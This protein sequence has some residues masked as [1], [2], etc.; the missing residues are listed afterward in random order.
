MLRR[1]EDHRPASSQRTRMTYVLTRP[2]T[3]EAV[4]QAPPASFQPPGAGTQDVSGRGT[5]DSRFKTPETAIAMSA[6]ADGLK[7]TE[8]CST[9]GTEAK[10]KENRSNEPDKSIRII[11][12]TL[13]TNLERT[14]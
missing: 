13:K 6:L 10:N 5:E 8:R 11:K 2:P 9:P 3:V 1:R 12:I 7:G 4:P 14:Q